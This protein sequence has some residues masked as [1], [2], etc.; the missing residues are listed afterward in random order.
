MVHDAAADSGDGHW[1]QDPQL[2]GVFVRAGV[3]AGLGREEQ[4]EVRGAPG[5]DREAVWEAVHA[6]PEGGA[7]RRVR[8]LGQRDREAEEHRVVG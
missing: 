3:A 2:R 6:V 1:E 8:G 4:E 5:G 7:E